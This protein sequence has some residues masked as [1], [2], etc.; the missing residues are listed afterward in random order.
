MDPFFMS[1]ARNWVNELLTKIRRKY[2]SRYDK[3]E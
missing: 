1:F 2:Y 3:V